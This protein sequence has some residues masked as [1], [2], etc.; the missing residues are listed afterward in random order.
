MLAI[1]PAA[2]A[3]GR[4]GSGQGQKPSQGQAQAQK[5]S[6]APEQGR[7]ATDRSRDQQRIRLTDQQQ[8]HYRAC[9]Q[10]QDR[11]RNQARDMA[12]LADRQG[13]TTEQAGQH[14]DRLR[15]QVRTMQE[16]HRLLM[17]GLTPEQQDAARAQIRNM[18]RA[19]ER[20][21]TRMAALD[22]EVGSDPF[23]FPRVTQQAREVER[24]MKEYQ[25]RHRQLGDK[26]GA[27]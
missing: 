22:S 10:S 9:T 2:L 20:L 27:S 6:R 26:I 3:Q 18:A 25:K 8:E 15:E 19:Q 24:A 13:F 21:Q 1:A 17:E 23:S 11:V 5:G 16:E 7:G 14:R 12:R 4:P